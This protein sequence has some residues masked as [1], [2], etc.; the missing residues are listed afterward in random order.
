[1]A[2]SAKSNINLNLKLAHL[3]WAQS[4]RTF[5]AEKPTELL[6]PTSDRYFANIKPADALSP[7]GAR[8]RVAIVLTQQMV[9]LLS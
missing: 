9:L 8:V 3:K 1:M 7:L 4:I 5:A 2:K 6:G